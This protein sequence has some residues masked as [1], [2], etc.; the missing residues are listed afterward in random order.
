MADAAPALPL[1]ILSAES[2]NL[3]IMFK[4][5]CRFLSAATSCS[6]VVLRL[7][8]DA[9]C[10]C[11]AAMRL[12]W[13]PRRASVSHSTRS[14]S[15][16]VAARAACLSSAPEA[17]TPAAATSSAASVCAPSSSARADLDSSC[18]PDSCSPARRAAEMPAALE[19]ASASA[20][21]LANAWC[22]AIEGAGAATDRCWASCWRRAKISAWR[23]AMS[24]EV[25][26]FTTAVFLIFLALRANLRVDSDSS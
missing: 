15:A 24:P 1:R 11:S 20:L 25:S 17:H 21:A 19:P 7:S 5:C 22:M 13:S 6:A 12:S 8:R 4:F 3:M 18:M 23:R 9:F 26:S 14:M 10:F 16:T 2:R